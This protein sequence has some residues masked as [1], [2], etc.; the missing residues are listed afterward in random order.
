[1]VLLS[2]TKDPLLSQRGIFEIL[3]K[4]ITKNREKGVLLV[5]KLQK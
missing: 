5:R 4:V 3:F 1:M 2:F